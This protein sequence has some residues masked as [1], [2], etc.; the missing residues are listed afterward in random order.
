[1]KLHMA[2][3]M[4]LDTSSA[5]DRTVNLLDGLLEVLIPCAR[6]LLLQACIM[7]MGMTGKGPVYE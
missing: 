4:Q 1:M 3:R 7:Q 5:I 2:P 6:L